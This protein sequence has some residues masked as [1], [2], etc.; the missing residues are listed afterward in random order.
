MKKIVYFLVLFILINNDVYSQKKSFLGLVESFDLKIYDYVNSKKLMSNKNSQFF[1]NY[2]KIYIYP[3]V[4][5]SELKY[6]KNQKLLL[7]PLLLTISSTYFLKY[8]T[9]RERPNK[10]NKMS[11]PSGHTSG[12]FVS[13]LIL[14]NNYGLSIG[15]PTLFLA[16]VVGMQRLES[17]N[18]WFS[19]VIS[20]AIIGLLFGIIK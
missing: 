2:G 6:N 16:S 7:N 12:S 9:K 15:V 20:G 13:A 18:H 3:F 4:I 19:D 1:D 5:Y 10:K 8:I 11:F 14:N 17:N